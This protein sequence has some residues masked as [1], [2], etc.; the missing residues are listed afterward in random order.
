MGLRVGE[1]LALQ[2]GDG[3]NHEKYLKNRYLLYSPSLF[4][5]KYISTFLKSK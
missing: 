1:A 5:H 4:A 2:I 3:K